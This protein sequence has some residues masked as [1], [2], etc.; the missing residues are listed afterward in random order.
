[1]R[2]HFE[3]QIKKGRGRYIRN[4]KIWQPIE[5]QSCGRRARTYNLLIQSQALCQLS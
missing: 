4:P 2:R 1:M 3:A 5:C